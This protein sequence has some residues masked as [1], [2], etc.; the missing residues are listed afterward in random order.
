MLDGC[1]WLPVNF[2]RVV[3]FSKIQAAMLSLGFRFFWSPFS[4]FLSGFKWTTGKI[5][6]CFEP[7]PVDDRLPDFLVSG[8]ELS[9][10]FDVDHYR[11][12]DLP[13]IRMVIRSEGS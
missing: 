3:T 6:F 13:T 11:G 2:K 8:P 1:P 4:D 12:N 7:L 5:G 9:V 10:D